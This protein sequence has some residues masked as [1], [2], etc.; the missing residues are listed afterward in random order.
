MI[1]FIYDKKHFRYK[2]HSIPDDCR[3]GN[4]RA[5]IFLTVGRADFGSYRNFSNAVG[6]TILK[7]NLTVEE[8]DRVDFGFIS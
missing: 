4:V 7:L 2:R 1:S 8:L 3:H 6:L 5:I